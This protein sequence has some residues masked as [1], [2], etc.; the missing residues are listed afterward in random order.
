[1]HCKKMKVHLPRSK[2]AHAI[3]KHHTLK[4]RGEVYAPEATNINSLFRWD[5]NH[6]STQEGISFYVY[7]PEATTATDVFYNQSKMGL[8]ELFAPKAK[9]ITNLVS[10]HVYGRYA[11]KP[12]LKF[13]L[14]QVT[15]ATNAFSYCRN[16]PD[17][18]FPTDWQY[19][20]YGKNMFTFCELGK[21]V[22]INILNSLPSATE[23]TG[24][25]IWCITIGVH[26]DHTNDEEVVAAITAAE[27]KGWTVTVQWNGTATAAASVSTYGLRRRN[28]VYAKLGAPMEDGKQPLDWGHYVTDPSGYM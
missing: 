27:E 11:K 13:T 1:M 18:D 23:E 6:N 2:N 10:P 24:T 26:V 9:N 20:K 8:A 3:L 22:A 16:V 25:D 19:L 7:A 14:G 28:P 21:E 12:R 4:E 17:S 15:N 5:L